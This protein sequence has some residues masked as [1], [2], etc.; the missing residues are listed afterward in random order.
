MNSLKQHLKTAHLLLASN[1]EK[2]KTKGKFS[3]SSLLIILVRFREILDITDAQQKYAIICN[4]HF[5]K[6]DY[7]VEDVAQLV[8]C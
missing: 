4:V 1:G 8:Q 5:Q 2:G 6:G 7:K 3:Q